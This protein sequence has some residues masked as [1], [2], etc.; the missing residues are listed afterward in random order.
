MTDEPDDL[1][2]ALRDEN[3]ELRARIA[4]L[5]ASREEY[6]RQMTEVLTSASWRVTAPLR[7]LVGKGRL[8]KRRVRE[9]PRKVGRTPTRTSTTG[10]FAPRGRLL[11]TAD[12]PLLALPLDWAEVAPHPAPLLE[13]RRNR[14]L[15]V[16]H[17]YYPEVWPD[18]E[19]RLSRLP[20]A[21]DLIVT[22]VRGKAESLENELKR[23]LPHARIHHVENHGRDFGPLIDLANRGLL[24]GY[25]AVLKVHTKRS[26]H[27]V[28]GDAW[29]ITLLDGVLPDPDAVRRIVDL[30]RKDRDVGLVAPTGHLKGAETWGSD[31]QLVEALAA[32]FPFAFDPDALLYAAGSMFWARPWVLER[33]ADLQLDARHF[34]PEAD[35]L[36]GSTAHALER[37]VGVLT[38]ASGLEQ[39]EVAD[40][41]SRLHKARRVKPAP[42]VLAFYL[43][44]YHQTAEND[45]WW[46]EGFTDWVNVEKARPL[47]DGHRQPIKPG[48]LGY[49]DLADPSVMR[50]QAALAREH[51][52]D[53]LV[54]YHYWFDGRPVLDTPL[55]NLLADPSIDLPFALCWA[56][57]NWTRRWDGLDSE[58]LI[59]QSYADG[60]ADRF[61]DDLLP[62]LRDPRYLRVE[63][64]PLLI[65]YRPG[66]VKG[67]RAA[68]ARWKARAAQD[69]LGGLH[70]LAVTPSRDFE[71]LPADV[72]GVLDG[73]VRFPP[74]NGIGLQS[75]LGL[76][77]DVEAGL[78]GDVYSYDTAVD[79]ADLST[80]GVHGLRLH[81][82]VMPG[83]DN[84]ARR[85][86]DAYV[87]H[88]GNPVSFR[89]WL[90]RAADA[91]VAGGPDPL[92]FVNAWNEWAEGAHLE[93]D[94]RFGRANLE[95]VQDVVRGGRR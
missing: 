91:A 54:M 21:Y 76:A 31:Q 74:G 35:H 33:L 56:N 28:D 30:L 8:A 81:P 63:G 10:L 29:R 65:V 47:Y 84:T 43:P 67:A 41:A 52:V 23:R 37:F 1:L 93:P 66:H 16:A 34:A 79:G 85:G 12:S 48:E 58:V 40:V 46:G 26:P 17:V 62:A 32:R 82:G 24:H 20:E 53:G 9:L 4:E 92:L 78:T 55:K 83:W 86:T 57:E 3:D 19:D 15:V 2:E 14:I 89:R 22:L 36:D 42:R 70:V 64:K 94:A 11:E 77:P 44:Q 45:G 75:V 88:G 27:R 49:Y 80:T 90:A 68:I 6:R 71:A 38:T 50:A 61:Y 7:G 72:A 18:I 69:G 13:P 59:G 60:W 5:E 25:D 73:L 51:G 39:V 95:A 87:F